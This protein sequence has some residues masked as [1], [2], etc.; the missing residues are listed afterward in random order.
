MNFW[1]ISSGLQPHLAL[2]EHAAEQLPRQR[3]L[4]RIEPEVRELLD[5]LELVVRRDEHLAERAGI[6]EAQQ[7]ALRERDHDVRVLRRLLPRRLRAAAA[8]PTCRGARSARRC[9]RAAARGTCPAAATDTILCPSSAPMNSFFCLWRRIDR[10]PATSTVLIFLPTTSFSRSRRMTSTSGSSGIA[11]LLSPVFARKPTA[12]D[13]GRGLLGLLLRAT[14]AFA[15][16][17]VTDEH[18]REEVLGVIRA[19]V[20]HDVPRPPERPRRGELLEAR[21]VVAAAR[22]RR[23]LRRCGPGGSAARG[24]ARSRARHRGRPRRRPL[25][26][27]RRGSTA[28]RGRRPRLRPCRAA[29]TRRGRARAATSASTREFTTPA[30][31]SESWPSGRC[32]KCSNT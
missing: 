8:V 20:A 15:V 7:P 1:S 24:R 9:R 21:L 22:D 19:L 25:R 13:P 31:T 26:T 6:D 23:R 10:R 14:F 3:G 29:G 12:R 28:W 32:G 5:L 11:P 16:A 4:E 27:R 17:L 30:R 2:G 18:R